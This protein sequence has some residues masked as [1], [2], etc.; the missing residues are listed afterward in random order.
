MPNILWICTDQQ[1]ID[2]LGCYGNEMVDTPNLDRLASKGVLFETAYC[3]SPICTPS[4]ASFLTGRYPRT[5]RCRQNG[6]E[7]PG[8]EVLVTK[9]LDQAGY[10]CGLSG[11]LHISPCQ[12]SV[13][14]AMEKRL[15]DGYSVFHWSHGAHDGWPTHEYFQWL[16]ERDKKFVTEDVEGTTLVARG[17]DEEYHQTTW[18]VE[19]AINFIRANHEYNM[20]W[21]FSVNFYDP[22]HPFDPPEKY[23]E[24]YMQRLDE[25]P[26]PNYVEGELDNKPKVQSMDHQGAYNNHHSNNANYDYDNM[27]EYEHKLV[28]ASYWAMVELI[29]KQVGRLLD[30]LEDTNQTEN[31]IVIFMS[32][33]GEM[34]GDH[35]IYLKG[36]YF[37]DPLAK[38]PLI[39]SWPGVFKEGIR[40]EALVELTDIAPTIMEAAGMEPWKG[41]QGKSFL[42]LLTGGTDCD[43]HRDSVYSEYYNA[44]PWH[45]DPVAFA[46]MVFDGRYKLVKMHG[47]AEGELYDLSNDP[48]ETINRWSDTEYTAVKLRMLDILCDRMA[49]TVDP[50]PS[51]ISE[52]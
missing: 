38:V 12:P 47:T 34:L 5:T 20:P 45:K 10:V 9:L 25:V 49:F 3:Q 14:K 46:T 21:M 15:D 40:S 28:R 11:K 43:K 42:G 22:H 17:M 37:Y 1:R 50:L 26:L 48:N 7:M 13:C 8:D 39:F 32:D 51:R 19:K 18:C 4:R 23:L 35:G 24:K 30:T 2:T 29:D 33:H 41:I 44:M 31:T 6:Q 27:S 52:W 16:R 36:P